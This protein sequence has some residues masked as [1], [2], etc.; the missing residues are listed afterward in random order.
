MYTKKVQK[1]FEEELSQPGD[2]TLVKY[3]IATHGDPKSFRSTLR[4]VAMKLHITIRTEFRD[5]HMFCHRVDVPPLDATVTEF[6]G[7]NPATLE[8]AAN[9]MGILLP[10]PSDPHYELKCGLVHAAITGVM[11]WKYQ[12]EDAWRKHN[13]G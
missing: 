1:Q 11:Q 3:N 10:M 5:D 12:A 2:V 13:E 6:N 8:K 9:L 7:A 4:Y